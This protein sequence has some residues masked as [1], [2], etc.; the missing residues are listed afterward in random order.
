MEGRRPAASFSVATG[1]LP[2]RDQQPALAPDPGKR[3]LQLESLPEHP[4]GERLYRLFGVLIGPLL[5]WYMFFDKAGAYVHIPGTPLY[6]AECL[7]LVAILASALAT[8]YLRITIRD[9]PLLTLLGFFILWGLART[10]PE[11]PKYGINSVRDAALWYYSL[12]AIFIV[13]VSRITPDIVTKMVNGFSRFFLGCWCGFRSRS[14]FPGC[15]TSRSRS[16]CPPSTSSS[17][18]RPMSGSWR[19]WHWRFSGSSQTLAVPNATA[20]S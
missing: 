4:I 10:I 3:P 15:T 7:L 18:A 8:G 17:T 19:W 6:L 16:P 1:L 9:D 5:V 20:S 13:V 14:F 2:P 11:L 12:F